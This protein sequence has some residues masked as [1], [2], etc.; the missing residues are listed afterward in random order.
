MSELYIMTKRKL[1]YN[2]IQAKQRK[3]NNESNTNHDSLQSTNT[4]HT[5]IPNE[6]MNEYVDSHVASTR[7]IMAKAKSCTFNG[8]HWTDKLN[9]FHAVRHSPHSER[10]ETTETAFCF[11]TEIIILIKCART[12]RKCSRKL[13]ERNMRRNNANS[14]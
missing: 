3:K 1:I 9:G 10:K 5:A 6:T 11:D 14:K 12:I 13:G 7:P 2:D 8:S 4:L